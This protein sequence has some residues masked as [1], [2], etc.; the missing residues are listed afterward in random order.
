MDTVEMP[1]L[2]ENQKSFAGIPEAVFL[3]EIDAFM[4]QPEKNCEKVL[5]Q[6]DEQHGK[7]RFMAYNLDTR[8]RKLKQ[9]IPILQKS[10]EMIDVLRN[11]TEARDPQFF[12]SDQVFIKTVVPPLKMCAFGW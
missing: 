12:L 4:D 3:D 1:K 5:Q 9:Q 2:P 10:L 8:R 7:Y 11:Q 6:L